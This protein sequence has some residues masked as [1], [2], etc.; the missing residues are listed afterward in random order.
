M[1]VSDKIRRIGNKI[2]QN[3][4]QHDLYRQTAKIL[5]LQSWKVSRYVR[6]TGK[7]VLQEKHL[8][9]KLPR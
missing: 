9:E 5:D 2:D 7:D 6:L 8:L 4:A 1:T 3:K